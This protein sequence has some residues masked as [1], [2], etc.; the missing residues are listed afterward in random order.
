MARGGDGFPTF[1][2]WSRHFLLSH[3]ARTGVWIH[4]EDACCPVRL[5]IVLS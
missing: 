4:L 2:D 5:Q 1:N 3:R